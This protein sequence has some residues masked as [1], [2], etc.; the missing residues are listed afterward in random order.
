[1]RPLL[2]V[3]AETVETFGVGPSAVRAAGGEVEVWD[4]I[5]GAPRPEPLAHDGVVL[6]G[7]SFNVEHADEQPFIRE[8]GEL[9]RATVDARIPFLGICFGA[10]ALAWALGG[11]VTKAPV[12][13]IG[14]EPITPTSAAADDPL[15]SHYEP[16]DRVFQWHMDTFD[17]PAGAVLLATGAQVPNQAIR[18]NETTWATQFHLE[19]DRAELESWLR[20][21]PDLEVEWGKSRAAILA[22]SDQVQTAHEAKGREVF[23]RFTRLARDRD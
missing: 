4:A 5:G 1:M 7:S 3:R 11:E 6:F 22:E 15:L 8:I 18:L 14:F 21:E 20:T 13:E 9:I 19:I 17:V 2:F 23:A 16:G 10:Q 12:R